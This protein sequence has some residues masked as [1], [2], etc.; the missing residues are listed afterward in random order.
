M[1]MNFQEGFFSSGITREEVQCIKNLTDENLKLKR[2]IKS[3]EK[4]LTQKNLD[5]EAVSDREKKNDELFF[6]DSR[7]T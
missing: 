2:T 4:E 6:I 5:L 1:I 3:K 7:S